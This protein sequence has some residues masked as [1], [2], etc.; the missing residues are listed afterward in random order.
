MSLSYILNNVSVTWIIIYLPRLM[1][2]YCNI[3]VILFSFFLSGISF[4]AKYGIGV[5]VT[6]PVFL[7]LVCFLTG[8]ERHVAIT[9]LSAVTNGQ[10]QPLP[11]IGMGLDRRTLES[12]P[13][14]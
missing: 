13:K 4:E 9:E 6:L 11:V 3:V 1:E 2:Q 5:G 10:V 14:D 12:Y 7:F 8:R